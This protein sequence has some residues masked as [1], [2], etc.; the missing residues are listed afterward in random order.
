MVK[1]SGTDSQYFTFTEFRVEELSKLFEPI[2]DKFQIEFFEIDRC[3]FENRS[4]LTEA[5]NLF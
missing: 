1:V 3:C 5:E 2:R 4:C